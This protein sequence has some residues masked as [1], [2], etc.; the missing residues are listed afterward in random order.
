MKII[1]TV[2]ILYLSQLGLF[3][4][5]AIK[6]QKLDDESFLTN[7]LNQYPTYF[8]ELMEKKDSFNIQII[9]TQIDRNKKGRQRFKEFHYNLNNAH[10][11]YPASTVKM[12]VAFL[13]LE[14][15]NDL[16][17]KGL[18]RHTTMVTDSGFTGQSIVYTQPNSADCRATIENYIKQIFLVSDNDAFNR[19]YEFVGQEAI[20]KKLA[21]KGY[22]DVIIKH[23]LESSMSLEE[24]RYT[25]PIRFYDSSSNLVYEQPL[26]YSNA[27]YPKLSVQMGN[28]YLKNGKLIEKPF[29]FSEKNRVYLQDLHHIL[30]SVLLPESVA[31]SKRF[32]IT[33]DDRNF[34]STWMRSFPRESDFPQ[35][36]SSVYWDS[37]CKFLLL[38]SERKLVPAN[39]EIFNKVGDAYGFLTDIAYIIDHDKG[40]E[41]LLSATIS[42]NRDG[43]YNDDQYDYDSI[44]YPF[45][46]HLGEVILKYEQERKLKI[47]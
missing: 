14:K 23:R 6:K 29:D 11:F 33:T 45:M 20:Q 27:I 17:I 5:T 36:D 13:A 9:Y 41:F 25:N 15:L 8:K 32:H 37:Y 42:C 47:R 34:L 3:A 35:Y 18:D 2:F 7:I 10:Y 46:K 43:I 26:Q 1:G 38:G 28:G 12:P 22:P 40:I 19:L 21:S 39:I 4:Q 24:N 44:G 30:Q 16:Q 31:A